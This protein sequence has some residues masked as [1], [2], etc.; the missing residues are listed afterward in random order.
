MVGRGLRIAEGKEFMILIDHVGNVQEHGLPCDVRTWTLDRIAR[1]GAKINFLRICANIECNAP[2]DRAFTECPWCGF[3]AI[4]QGGGG[5]T[6]PEQVDGDLFL[7][8][9]ETLRELEAKSTLEDPGRLAQR[10][11]SAVNAAAG[12]KAMKNQQERIA[13]QKVLAEGIANWAGFVKKKYGY[14]DRQINKKFYLIHNKTI[15]E[16]LGEPKEQMI[17]TME[18]LI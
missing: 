4:S 17:H 12:I 15:T 11:S 2:Y 14:T 6:L 5:K 3:E 9:P 1:R 13:Y 16:A 7:V 8:D 10:V 18:N